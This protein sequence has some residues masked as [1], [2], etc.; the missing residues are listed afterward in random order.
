MIYVSTRV[1][2]LRRNNIKNLVL[3]QYNRQDLLNA[4]NRYYNKAEFK[5]KVYR[6][7]FPFNLGLLS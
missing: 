1:L 6:T 4:F 2:N 3:V 7:N 5:D